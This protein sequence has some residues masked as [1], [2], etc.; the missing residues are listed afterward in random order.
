MFTSLPIHLFGAKFRYNV[1]PGET[2][3]F[4]SVSTISVLDSGIPLENTTVRLSKH[5]EVLDRE[6]LASKFTLRT[7][8]DGLD[9]SWGV[10]VPREER[11]E[12][13]Y[14]RSL[15]NDQKITVM[16]R[17][18]IPMVGPTV[19]YH[20]ARAIL[21][22]KAAGI[23][24]TEPD[25]AKRLAFLLNYVNRE[26]ND[27][28]QDL[29]RQTLR[30]EAAAYAKYP[31][32]DPDPLNSVARS[33]AV[34]SLNFRPA[35]EIIQFPE[36]RFGR[37]DSCSF[38]GQNMFLQSQFFTFKFLLPTAFRVSGF[39][40]I[41]DHMFAILEWKEEG[42]IAQVSP[43]PHVVG[44]KQES[45]LQGQTEG[46]MWLRLDNGFVEKVEGSFKGTFDKNSI[47]INKLKLFT[48]GAGNSMGDKLEVNGTI[49]SKRI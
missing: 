2:L 37:G 28:V 16:G 4:E 21:Q 40:T 23:G 43:M 47:D 29:D 5:F 49:S 30:E 12:G 46:K 42:V 33:L 44:L 32:L 34:G 48:N 35:Q 41:G 38:E 22:E 13:G 17:Y 19:D 14:F 10:P 45:A 18:L 36:G 15:Q 20:R 3:R 11:F 31:P 7:A 27:W 8:F 25:E 1:K 24:K 9:V 39:K 26:V 6:G